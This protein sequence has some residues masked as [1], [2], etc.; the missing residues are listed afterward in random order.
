MTT[1]WSSAQTDEPG[2][3]RLCPLQP[4]RPALRIPL[5][6]VQL[7]T[8]PAPLTRKLARDGLLQHR[9]MDRRLLVRDPR[10]PVPGKRPVALVDRF[11]LREVAPCAAYPHELAPGHEPGPAGL[12]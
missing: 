10:Q 1:S 7:R 12:A 4:V 3:R 6:F 11:D 5:H 8:D 2:R 9:V